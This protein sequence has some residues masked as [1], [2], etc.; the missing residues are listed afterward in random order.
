M[1]A[2]GKRPG[3]GRKK[4]AQAV[5]SLPDGLQPIDFFIGTMRGLLY[6]DDKWIDPATN[7][8]E[9]ISEED[10]MT[11]AKAAAPYMYP[12]LANVDANVDIE[13]LTIEI[14]KYGKD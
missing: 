13:G 12:K 14:V 3:S 7:E 10:R 11:A 8:E 5:S 9:T 1:T 4:K 2:G 6:R